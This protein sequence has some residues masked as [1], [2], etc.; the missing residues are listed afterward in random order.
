MPANHNR[1]VTD[2]YRSTV[3]SSFAFM[4][5]TANIAE[6]LVKNIPLPNGEGVLLPICDL[7]SDDRSLIRDLASWRANH[8]T[9]YPTRFP[10]TEE[11]TAKWLQSGL[12]N[13]DDRI[14]FLVLDRHGNRVGHLG[15]ANCFSDGGFMEVDNVIRGLPE[16]SPG[17]MGL[18]LDTIL[19][20]ARTTIGAQGFFLRV[21]KDNKHAVT[22]YERHGF[23]KSTEIPLRRTLDGELES[24]KPLES[25]DIQPPDAIFLKMT[26]CP[27]VSVGQQ[28]ILT[29][30][31]SI[32]ERESFYA[33][34]AARYGWNSKWNSYLTWFEQQF[35]DYIGVKHCLATSSGTG[36]L[37]IALQA[38]EIGPGDEV[39]VPDLT[40]V[41][42]ANAVRYV[43]ATP[44]F[45]DIELDTWNMD[46]KSAEVLI[47]P[48]TKAIMPVHMYGHPARMDGIMTLARKH[49]LYVIEDAAPAIGAE[50][51]GQRCGSFG[52]FA[53][54]SFQGAKLLVTGEGGMLVCSNTTLYEKAL[55]VWDQGRDPKKTFWIDSHGL[56]YKMSNI[57]AAI[58]LG[59]LERCSELIS[60]K[61]RIFEW[62]AERLKDLKGIHLN[63]ESSDAFS[64]YW[65]SSLRLDENIKVSRNE[66]A[67][68][69]KKRNVDTRPVFPAISQYPIWGRDV[70]P[71]PTALRVGQQAMNLPSGVC[72]RR[73][74][75]DYVCRQIREILDA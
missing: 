41:A 8:Q 20:W 49:G 44:I 6:L 53:A 72:L 52:D 61:R 68:E 16:N 69:L 63:F 66:L 11:G 57:Q 40:W 45:A 21:F 46:V 55:K 42:T 36:A 58:G 3:D 24:F 59:Q 74:H 51:K 31:P 18:A 38:L 64:I 28:I 4:K 75:V 54:F 67:V 19:E 12:L 35:A 23:T 30:G 15:F 60:M 43:G 25:G 29:A 39:I 10:V 56:K 14:L 27:D 1:N 7:H 22:F 32:S 26:W 33:W 37:H 34:D 5:R 71:Q 62:Y 50:W 70:T 65:M 17:I 13:I 48:R 47:T 2:I 73:E 9:A